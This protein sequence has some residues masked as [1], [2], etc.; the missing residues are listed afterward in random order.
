M[1]PI[2]FFFDLPWWTGLP[3]FLLG[4]ALVLWLY[5]LGILIAL[6]GSWTFFKL[7]Q[8]SEFNGSAFAIIGFPLFFLSMLIPE[9]FHFDTPVLDLLN[10]LSP[11]VT[12]GIRS[13]LSLATSFF[14]FQSFR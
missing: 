5:P 11:T 12:Y 4:T 2:Q 3:I 13:A 1:R 8:T 9:Q 10:H 6:F 14:A 7:M